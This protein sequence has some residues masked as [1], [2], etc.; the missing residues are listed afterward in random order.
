MRYKILVSSTLAAL[1]LIVAGCKKDQD[2]LAVAKFDA[3]PATGFGLSNQDAIVLTINAS[4]TELDT[5]LEVFS[6]AKYGSDTKVT[7]VADT[8]VVNTYNTA[9]GKSFDYMPADVY[10]LPSTIVIPPNSQEGTGKLAVNITKLLTHGTSFALG[11]T[12]TTVSGG[13]GKV[14]TQHSHLP[15]IIQ[16]KNQY[17]AE[18]TVTGTM[19]DFASAGLSGPYPWDVFLITAGPNQVLLFDNDY[20]GD[21]FHKI[22]SGAADSY[23]GGFGVVFNFDA[24]GNVTSV[25]NYYGQPNPANT[26]SAELDPSGINKFDPVTKTLD[27]KYWMNQPSV[28]SPHRTSFTEHF[29]YVGPRP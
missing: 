4:T 9:N 28:I 11:L 21:I 3:T 23:Y 18:Y 17:D 13:T 25:L 27:V 6:S 7:I 5:T 26:R 14:L 24:N 15:V 22:K 1:L 16:V 12:I 29:T 10:T 19:V 8:A 2:F 20:T